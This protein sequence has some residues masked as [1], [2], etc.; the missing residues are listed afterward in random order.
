MDLN[1]WNTHSSAVQVCVFARAGGGMPL[2]KCLK[3]GPKVVKVEDG[4]GLEAR[5]RS[6]AAGGGE[7]FGFIVVTC[8]IL[9]IVVPYFV[10][11]LE[12][13]FPTGYPEK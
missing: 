7:K 10:I 3:H 13:L 8:N 1:E 5:R 6:C 2:R 4:K 11:F 9:R 12:L